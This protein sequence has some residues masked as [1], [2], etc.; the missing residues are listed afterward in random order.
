MTAPEKPGLSN[1]ELK[2]YNLVGDL[3]VMGPGLEDD[4]RYG[5]A[6]DCLEAEHLNI[7]YAEGFKAGRSQEAPQGK[8][9]WSLEVEDARTLAAYWLMTDE[10]SRRE[11][12]QSDIKKICEQLLKATEVQAALSG[13]GDERWEKEAPVAPVR[14]WEAD[15]KA[16]A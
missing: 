16:I 2:P 11:M 3:Y 10:R 14:K 13:G 5:I 1:E 8:R 12:W 9:E 7:A 4:R 15:R 6:P